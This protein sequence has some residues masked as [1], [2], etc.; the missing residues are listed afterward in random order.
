MKITRYLIII[1]V[2][3]MVNSCTTLNLP[4]IGKENEKIDAQIETLLADPALSPAHIGI[5][6]KEM[7]SG[8][9]LYAKN[10]HKLLMP[11]SNMKLVTTAAGL[12]ILGPDFQ[13]ET[14]FFTDGKIVNGILKGNLFIK[15][16]GDPTFSGRFYKDNPDSV[17][18]LWAEKLKS[19]GINKI[20]GEIIGDNSIFQDD[21]LGY[22]W[23]KDDLPYY[24]AAKTSGLSFNDNCIDLHFYPDVHIGRPVTIK[25]TPV[26][27]YLPIKNQRIT[28]P[29]D[30]SNR[31][32]FIRNYITDSLIVTGQLPI[33]AAPELDW[34]TVPNPADFFLQEFK[35]I[36]QKHSISFSGCKIIDTSLTYENK[37]LL[38]INRSVPLAK[39]VKNIN[40]V[41]NNYYAE[42]LLKTLCNDQPITTEKAIKREKDFFRRIGIDSDRMFIKDGS[43]LSRHNMVT[44]HQIATILNYM[45]TGKNGK[46]YRESLPVAGVDGTLKRRFKGS[47][48]KGHVFAKTGYVG[49]VRALSGYVFAKNDKKYVFSII[50]NHYP[51]P[52][53]YINR[54]QDHIV[55]L[56]Y[57]QE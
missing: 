34:A 8:E 39:I 51:T 21:G 29:P 2:G 16:S 40:K 47:N 44:V 12:S 14:G 5:Y 22:G 27:Q 53:S 13:Y 30:S 46:L 50:V 36:L 10:Q 33:D 19:L 56:I 45:A 32:Q 42:T 20:D 26:S 1:F 57:N 48:A 43:G 55:T 31:S 3:V 28:V 23:E 9:I 4:I 25:Q 6:I 11:A 52:T 7:E 41:S 18:I 35:K 37:A 54:L 49:H 17:F 24:Y 38:F 15:G